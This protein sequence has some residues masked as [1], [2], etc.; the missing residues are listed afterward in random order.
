MVRINLT[1][2]IGKYATRQ[3]PCSRKFFF[4]AFPLKAHS[5]CYLLI[6]DKRSFWPLLLTCAMNPA[7]VF[8]GLRPCISL[9]YW[10]FILSLMSF[11]SRP[12]AY[13]KSPPIPFIPILYY[14]TEESRKLFKK[15][16]MAINLFSLFYVWSPAMVTSITI[17]LQT[18]NLHSEDH[19]S[20][21]FCR[22]L[23]VSWGRG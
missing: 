2:L 3:W 15:K 7:P 21:P 9:L 11:F 19:V 13:W 16:S 4:G 12:E 17:G 10:G 22:Y 1:R 6:R 23:N 18:P 8:S 5:D 20:Y 14:R